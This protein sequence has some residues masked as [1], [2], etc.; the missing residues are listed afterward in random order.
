MTAITALPE[1]LA[2]AEKHMRKIFR[3]MPGR[4][5]DARGLSRPVPR[6]APCV[7]R[8]AYGVPTQ[9]A[10]LSHQSGGAQRAFENGAHSA[11]CLIDA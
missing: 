9:G 10:R 8:L 1:K 11:A 4:L 6:F 7:E 2:V 5:N 3:S